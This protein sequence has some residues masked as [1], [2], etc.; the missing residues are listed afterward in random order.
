MYE[1]FP[2][3]YKYVPRIVPKS[4]PAEQ[5]SQRKSSSPNNFAEDI[6][7]A[8]EAEV[9]SISFFLLSRDELPSEDMLL[10]VEGGD[11]I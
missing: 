7:Y 4:N 2:Y 9:R 8:V 1:E 5:P 6:I 11:I 10:L 3:K